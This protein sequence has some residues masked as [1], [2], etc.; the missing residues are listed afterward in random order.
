MLNSLSNTHIIYIDMIDASRINFKN[1]LFMSALYLSW[2]DKRNSYDSTLI[3][4][5]THLFM[6]SID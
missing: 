2:L 6:S 3:L 5:Y 4:L 1:L